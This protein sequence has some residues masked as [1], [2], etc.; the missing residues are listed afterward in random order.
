MSIPFYPPN[1]LHELVY[2]PIEDHVK[3]LMFEEVKQLGAECYTIE[4]T[5]GNLIKKILIYV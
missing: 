2:S 5:T 4:K 1:V 3:E